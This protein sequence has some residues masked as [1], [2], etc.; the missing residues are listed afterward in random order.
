MAGE[1]SDWHCVAKARRP[2]L[3]GGAAEAG[4]AGCSTAPHACVRMPLLI[5]LQQ[6][7]ARLV[8]ARQVPVPRAPLGEAAA[9][10]QPHNLWAG[11]I[12]CDAEV[13][14]APGRGHLHDGDAVVADAMC[15]D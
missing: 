8:S 1:R 12:V 15:R 2:G 10:V 14:R 13:S 3:G 7:T 4:K 9:P 5:R 11:R 6:L